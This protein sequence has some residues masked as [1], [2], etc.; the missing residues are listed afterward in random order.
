MD[1]KT[2]F[3]K[4]TISL[5]VNYWASHAATKMWSEWDESVV[6]NDIKRLADI[7][8]E[9]LRVFPLWPDFQP[10]MVLRSNCVKGGYKRGYAFTGER[11]IPNTEAGKAGIDEKMMERFEKLC[12]IARK[13]NMKLIIPLIN[14]HMTFRIYNPPA[15]DGLDHFKDQESLMWQGK[16][17]NYFVKRM[18]NHPAIVAWEIG[19][20]SNCLSAAD[21]R[22]TA[23]SWSSFIVNAIRAVDNTRPV[24]SGMHNLQC[25]DS[26]SNPSVTSWTFADQ[27]EICDVLTSHPYPMWRP[28]INRDKPNTLRWVLLAATENQL[29]AD[30]SK[31]ESFAEEAGTLRRTFSTFDALGDHLRNTLWLLWSNDSRALFWWC[32]FDQTKME[33]PPYDWDEAGME[34]GILTD[35]YK[36]NPTGRAIFDFAEFKK[37]CPVKELPEPKEKAVCILGRDQN[38]YELANSVGVLAKQAGLPFEFLFCED[39]IPDSKVYMIPCAQRKGGINRANY[40]KLFEQAEKGATVYVSFDYNTSIPYM[41]EFFGLEIES[42]ELNNSPLNLKIG[43]CPT[44]VLNPKYRFI[45]KSHGA[46]TVDDNGIVWEYK[47]GKGRIIVATL[48]YE[49][50]MLNVQNSYQKYPGFELYR[51]IGK[52]II[53]HNVL[54]STDCEVVISEHPESNETVYA[55]V[56]N[57]SPNFKNT[58]IEI[59]EGW[60][61]ETYYSDIE[62]V[63]CNNNIITLPNNCGALLLLKKEE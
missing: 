58:N 23:W 50:L 34:H 36:I 49:Y 40:R 19:N 7:G 2:L 42:R 38:T 5:G 13:Y 22:A 46:N 45:I 30:I 21:D 8:C 18:M 56:C 57:C 9:Y 15:L 25:H 55:I 44:I 20:E 1:K 61:V 59:K 31:S 37:I 27:A 63:S 11:P 16:F 35:D 33:F 60:K 10:I 12:D 48:P 26:R 28:Y 41:D 39:E 51:M 4:G 24:C 54:K 53:E 47:V 62:A 3:K 6:E 14:G 52:E 43:D 17:I 32:A 29:F